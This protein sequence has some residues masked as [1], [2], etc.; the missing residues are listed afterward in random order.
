MY[1]F[2]KTL[3]IFFAVVFSLTGIAALIGAIFYGATHQYAT[4]IACA[5]FAAICIN[6]YKTDKKD[7]N[8]KSKKH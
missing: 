5:I 4:T 1:S 3:D 6:D 8:T 7:D 2:S